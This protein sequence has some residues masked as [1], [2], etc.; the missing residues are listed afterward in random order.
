MENNNVKIDDVASFCNADHHLEEYRLVLCAKAMEIAKDFRDFV[1]V[2]PKQDYEPLM[3]RARMTGRNEKTVEV[4]WQ[5]RHYNNGRVRWIYI[6]KGANTN[7][8]N[9]NKLKAKCKDTRYHTKIEETETALGEIRGMLK[10]AQGAKR[11]MDG[12]DNLC[13]NRSRRLRCK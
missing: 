13:S 12:I 3:L 8:Y 11:K 10:F 7:S 5:L 1:A 6:K 2:L 4:A 9:I